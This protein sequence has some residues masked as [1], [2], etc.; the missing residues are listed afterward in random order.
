M[1]VP[2]TPRSSFDSKRSLGLLDLPTELKEQIYEYC[3]VDVSSPI[4][5]IYR[6]AQA[7]NWSFRQIQDGSFP[8]LLLVCQ[9][10]RQ[11]VLT[12]LHRITDGPLL[13]INPTIMPER[14]TRKLHL[15]DMAD[16][17]E[18]VFELEPI[19]TS[20]PKIRLQVHWPESMTRQAT[21]LA[22]L[23]WLVATFNSRV[24][25]L[26]SVRAHLFLD[27]VGIWPNERDSIWQILGQVL[28]AEGTVAYVWPPDS[29]RR[30]PCWEE[31]RVAV[32]HLPGRRWENKNGG[33]LKDCNGAVG[34]TR[35]AREALLA[36]CRTTW[37][38]RGF[39]IFP[40]T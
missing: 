5:V 8:A 26:E 3:L 15:Y 2:R 19:L 9:I 21:I 4:Y 23:R 13:L 38:T 12:V 11:E 20:I 31:R 10:M 25:V 1:L 16:E 34:G 32:R 6:H 14:P 35:A 33:A 27:H 39:R 24:S 22:L 36:N 29:T 28:C 7:N 30:R 18:S 37:W 17:T 40:W